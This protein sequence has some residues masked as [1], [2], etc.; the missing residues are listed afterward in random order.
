M[1]IVYVGI[2]IGAI[3]VMGTDLDILSYVLKALMIFLLI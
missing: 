1:N 2:S 3:I